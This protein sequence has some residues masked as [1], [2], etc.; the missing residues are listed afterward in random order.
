MPPYDPGLPAPVV[1]ALALLSA[2]AAPP[3]LPPATPRVIPEARPEVCEGADYDMIT[4]GTTFLWDGSPAA[5]VP[6][7][8]RGRPGEPPRV[9]TRSGP[10]GA[11][12]IT[13]SGP[14]VLYAP[15]VGRVPRS[16]CV[17]IPSHVR[18][19]VPEGSRV[20]MHV[21]ET[22]FVADPMCPLHVEAPAWTSAGRL[23]VDR[24]TEVL[25]LD[26]L[27]PAAAFDLTVPC[28]TRAIGVE[29]ADG[30]LGG[31]CSH[32]L[33]CVVD[34][35]A[36]LTSPRAAPVRVSTG[37]PGAL[38][39]SPWGLRRADEV[40]DVAVPWDGQ[41]FDVLV[42]ADGMAPRAARVDGPTA[43]HLLPAVA[44][45]VRCVGQPDDR[46][47]SPP[48]MRY[49]AAEAPC[50]MVDG[51]GAVCDLPRGTPTRVGDAG[52]WAEVQVDG[53]EAPVVQLD[54]RAFTSVIEGEVAAPACDVLAVRQP[55]PLQRW[56]ADWLDVPRLRVA[57]ASC[58]ERGRYA[59]RGLSPGAWAL[60]V[61]PVPGPAVESVVTAAP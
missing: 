57:R 30:L 48:R 19:Q 60:R 45:E 42:T 22:N 6:I 36:Q 54:H 28:D 39:D 20:R 58:D 26:E 8:E 17:A 3:P 29:G 21:R 53:E 55:G 40:G 31:D 11:W 41:P 52:V 33:A 38:V 1:G 5:G 24:V 59:L 34:G 35:R 51:F 15:G 44:V 37:H 25:P 4:S 13:L 50:R 27:Q 7:A 32:G 9:L 18:I 61:D 2:C 56:A 49:D 14:Q 47:P 10:D 23:L 16:T 46:C 12:Q 43:I